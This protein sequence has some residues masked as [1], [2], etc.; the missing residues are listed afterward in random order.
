MNWMKNDGLGQVL[1]CYYLAKGKGHI[2]YQNGI[3]T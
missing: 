1:E 3:F 2:I